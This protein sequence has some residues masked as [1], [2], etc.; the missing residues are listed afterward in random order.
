V[1]SYAGSLLV[2]T[3]QLIDPHFWRTVA[4]ILHHDENGCVGLVLNRPTLEKVSDHLDSWA[5]TVREP[6]V[7]FYGGPVEPDVGIALTTSSRGESTSLPGVFLADLTKE[8]PDAGEVR[9]FSGYSGWAS[10]QLEAEIA[11]GSWYVVPASPDDPFAEPGE[12]WANV[13]RRQ[14]GHL[15]L[16]S[17]FPTDVSLN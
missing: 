7:V 4:L 11:E 16:V 14:R 3:P 6:D 1:T 12:Q 9:I 15:S 13:L 5:V 2:A 10:G 17:T 8:P